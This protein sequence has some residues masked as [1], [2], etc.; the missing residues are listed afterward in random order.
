VSD[1][2][3]I[4]PLGGEGPHDGD[5]PMPPPEEEIPNGRRRRHGMVVWDV[6]D[7]VILVI[8]RERPRS[9]LSLLPA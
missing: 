6:M 4:H 2:L 3:S 5:E 8:L 1:G 7:K 9:K